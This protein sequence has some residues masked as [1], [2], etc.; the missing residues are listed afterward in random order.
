MRRAV[1]LLVV[2]VRIPEGADFSFAATELENHLETQAY[3]HDHHFPD[4]H[5]P[6]RLRRAD[7]V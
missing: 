5:E 4:D 3:L 1:A 7:G 6:R 2:V